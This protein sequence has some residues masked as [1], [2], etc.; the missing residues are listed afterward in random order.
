MIDEAARTRVRPP[1]TFRSPPMTDQQTIEELKA[2]IDELESQQDRLRDDLSRAQMDE[3]EGRLD[4][5]GLQM[6][7]GTMELRDRL[8]PIV[9]Q[10]RRQIA[11]A[12]A[13][14]ED[15]SE[16]TADAVAALRAGFEQ[17]WDDLRSAVNDAKSIVS[18]G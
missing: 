8:D 6:H 16:T 17:A 9:E 2:R 10:A 13:R 5:V 15:G 14:I 1:P 18:S 4:D 3:W 12:R 11:D 7:L